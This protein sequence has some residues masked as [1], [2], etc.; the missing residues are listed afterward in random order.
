M[1][2]DLLGQYTSVSNQDG[3][4]FVPKG[5]DPGENRMIVSYS[6]SEKKMH[7]VGFK[8]L[9]EMER[10]LNFVSG[11]GLKAD[12]VIDGMRYS[13]VT[14]PNRSVDTQNLY[15]QGKVVFVGLSVY[16]DSKWKEMQFAIIDNRVFVNVDG[17]WVLYNPSVLANTYVRTKDGKIVRADELIRVEDRDKSIRGYDFI[18]LSAQIDRFYVGELRY[19]RPVSI[20]QLRYS[21]I[22]EN[23]DA[24]EHQQPTAKIKGEPQVHQP[25]IQRLPD[26]VV[27]AKGSFVANGKTV[28]LPKPHDFRDLF[29]PVS[30]LPPTYRLRD[31]VRYT[32]EVKMINLTAKHSNGRETEL[33]FLVAGG[34]VLFRTD[35][36][37]RWLLYSPEAINLSEYSVMTVDGKYIKLSD[38]LEIRNNLQT[39][40]DNMFYDSI[41]VRNTDR[42]L[43]SVQGEGVTTNNT[44]LNN[45][46][47]R[48][49][50]RRVLETG[51][52]QA[53][54]PSREKIVEKDSKNNNKS[55][56]P[57]IQTDSPTS[58]PNPTN[59][60]TQ[61][62]EDRSR[63]RVDPSQQSKP[64]VAERRDEEQTGRKQ[65]KPDTARSD[66]IRDL[67]SKLNPTDRKNVTDAIQNLL[68]G[69]YSWIWFGVRKSDLQTI[70]NWFRENF[71]DR[72]VLRVIEDRGERVRVRVDPNQQ[73]KP[74]VAERRDEEQTGRKQPKPDQPKPTVPERLDTVPERKDTRQERDRIDY[75]K[76]TIP[77]TQ[78]PE[79]QRP[80]TLELTGMTLERIDNIRE[81]SRRY[82]DLLKSR[83]IDP[84]YLGM[85]RELLSKYSEKDIYSMLGLDPDQMIRNRAMLE[86]TDRLT[87]RKGISPEEHLAIVLMAGNIGSNREN[88]DSAILSQGEKKSIMVEGIE[89]GLTLRENRLR[90]ETP[91]GISVIGLGDMDQDAVP[92]VVVT[93]SKAEVVI[94]DP[95]RLDVLADLQSRGNVYLMNINRTD[96][97]VNVSLILL[98]RLENLGY[99][100]NDTVET[101][102]PL[103]EIISRLGIPSWMGDVVKNVDRNPE[104]IDP[105]SVNESLESYYNREEIELLRKVYDMYFANRMRWEDFSRLS[106]YYFQKPVDDIEVR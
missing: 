37:D 21:K 30:S 4:L 75:G 24:K 76:Q 9:N 15:V 45:M 27:F 6:E 25:P 18:M 2:G 82:A 52:R 17:K 31:N 53:D 10:M 8:D 43:I 98:D 36:D 99:N 54:Q 94:I 90:V 19:E 3:R 61:D 80:G 14:D 63:A 32:G 12:L 35:R 96:R 11:K 39:I 67:Y 105:N 100:K 23:R 93:G 40:G 72:Y 56:E 62:G 101:T 59:R 41:I 106:V 5:K 78:Q 60:K 83:S 13:V 87:G 47:Y 86:R 50:T 102:V 74:T 38:V 26:Q 1:I 29:E 51:S 49:A 34:I 103:D 92:V 71:G 33:Y 48:D 88:T 64:T 77:N 65:P 68:N 89:I 81:F 20:H 22:S 84:K 69:K 73:S 97:S 44:D 70:Q 79:R 85:A 91:S 55:S 16:R 28:S 42:V 95:N 58:K 46:I 104:R 57:Q 7:E 66:I